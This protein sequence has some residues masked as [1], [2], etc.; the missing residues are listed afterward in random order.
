MNRLL[1]GDNLKWPRDTRIFPDAH[2][3]SM[4][5]QAVDLVYLDPP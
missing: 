1:L 5:G 3:D 2:P 4:S